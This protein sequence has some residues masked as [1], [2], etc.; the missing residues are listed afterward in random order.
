MD[1]CQNHPQRRT[2]QIRTL[3]LKE[4]HEAYGLV[5]NIRLLSYDEF[6]DLV[7]EMR[8]R[9]TMIGLFERENLL[10]FAGID[11]VTTLKDGRHIRVY[12]IVAKGA[13]EM[14]H[15][16]AYLEDYARISAAKKVVYE[17]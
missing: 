7:Y 16:R 3:S 12:D 4:L 1:I 13:Q 14:R 2:V 11:I 6:E 17:E 10:A 15:L 5:Q 8:D 9:Y